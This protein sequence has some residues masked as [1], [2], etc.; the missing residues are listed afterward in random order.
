MTAFVLY[1]VGSAIV[2]EYVESCARAG[3]ALVAGI[4]NRDVPSFLPGDVRLVEAAAIDDALLAA[5]CLCPLFTP[6]N[7]FTATNEARQ[8]GF[9]FSSALTD[10]TAIVASDVTVGGGS[11][12]NAGVII[13]AATTIAGDVVINRGASIGHHGRIADFA[14]IGPGVTIAGQVTIGR[15]AMIG[16]G[17]V[18]GPTVEIGA[19]AM[20]G[21]GAVV[22]T[23]VPAHRKVF[24][25]SASL[26][27]KPVDGFDA[28]P[29]P[30][31]G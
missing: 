1:G 12:V 13:G 24:R 21:A 18:I 11:Y 27:A 23:D 20:V 25:A 19:H 5:A 14:S 22:L 3:H 8:R 10:P 9:A 17:A 30:G 26:V 31:P 2:V 7:R 15:G 29:D 16:A 4:A 28:A 6:T